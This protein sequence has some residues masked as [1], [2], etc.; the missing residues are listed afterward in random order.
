M[1]RRFAI[2][3]YKDGIDTLECNKE[4]E[5]CSMRFICF[6]TQP[7]ELLHVDRGVNPEIM[8]WT[9]IGRQIKI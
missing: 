6:T 9:Y 7:S 5:A 1:R 4:C 8:R 3:E 2:V